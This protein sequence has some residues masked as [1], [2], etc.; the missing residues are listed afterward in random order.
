MTIEAVSERREDAILLTGF[1]DERSVYEPSKLGDLQKLEKAKQNKPPKTKKSNKTPTTK[2][3]KGFYIERV[4]IKYSIH[5]RAD[6]IE[7][8][9]MRTQ[10][11]KKM[12][13]KLLRKI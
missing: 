3:K 12:A 6:K 7:N 1:D 9:P 8:I 10:I 5:V 11:M 4:T 2:E 13:F